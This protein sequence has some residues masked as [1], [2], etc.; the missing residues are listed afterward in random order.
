MKASKKAYRLQLVAA[1]YDT[2]DGEYLDFDE[3]RLVVLGTVRS[4][5]D[6]HR[7]AEEVTVL[8]DGDADVRRLLVKED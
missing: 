8:T 7:F 1:G 4:L 2:E 6:A 3:H 5:K